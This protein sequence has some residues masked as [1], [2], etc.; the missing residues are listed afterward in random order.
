MAYSQKRSPADLKAQ[1]LRIFI[2]EQ[3]TRKNY[4]I[5]RKKMIA[6]TGAKDL[7]VSSGSFRAVYVYLTSENNSKNSNLLKNTKKNYKHLKFRKEL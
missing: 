1:L 2:F 6:L 3:F 4:A 5:Y 7:S